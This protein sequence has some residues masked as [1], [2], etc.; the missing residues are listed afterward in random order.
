MSTDTLTVPELPE[1]KPVDYLTMTPDGIRR[2]VH[3]QNGNA[4]VRKYADLDDIDLYDLIIE[5]QINCANLKE[6]WEDGKDVAERYGV[7]ADQYA[8]AVDEAN[9]RRLDTRRAA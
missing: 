9:T 3:E 2:V 8:Q 5:A 7:W 4:K 6:L 1:R